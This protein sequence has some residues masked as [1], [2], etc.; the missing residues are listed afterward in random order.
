MQNMDHL[1]MASA[2]AATYHPYNDSKPVKAPK[3]PN[4]PKRKKSSFD[5]FRTE[6]MQE[7]KRLNP[8][9][10][11]DLGVF[12][13]NLSATWSSLTDEKKTPYARE[14]E[15]DGHRFE[16]E[17]ANYV[18]APQFVEVGKKKKRKRIK[19]PGE[20]KR[21][22]T[23]FMFFS[24]L[25]RSGVVKENPELRIGGIA[26]ILGERWQKMD[27]EERAPYQ[28]RAD[29]DKGRYATQLAAFRLSKANGTL[30]V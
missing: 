4:K 21:A 30:G 20:P 11:V 19:E 16:L 9:T 27:E 26:K 3:D 24:N 7:F 13:T 28:Q 6:Q 5:V 18:P 15:K 12:M 25:T 10:K 8:D 29:D 23:A 17:M 1:V 14:A 22:T 2:M